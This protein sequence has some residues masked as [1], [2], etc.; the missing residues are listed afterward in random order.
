M[1]ENKTKQNKLFDFFQFSKT[2]K[3]NNYLPGKAGT[4]T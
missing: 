4:V 1:G 2:L 3:K